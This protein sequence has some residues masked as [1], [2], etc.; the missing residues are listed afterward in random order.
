MILIISISSETL[1]K[2]Y[3]K[4][5]S[6][7]VKNFLTKKTTHE[8]WKYDHD[9]KN[10]KICLVDG[11]KNVIFLFPD[12]FILFKPYQFVYRVCCNLFQFTEKRRRIKTSVAKCSA[13]AVNI[14]LFSTT[15]RL[16]CQKNGFLLFSFENWFSKTFLLGSMNFFLLFTILGRGCDSGGEVLKLHRKVIM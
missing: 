8:N 7:S 11:C 5:I 15:V 2:R 10:L 14:R 16:H 9:Q 12:L 1:I 3:P 4:L 13:L 6:I